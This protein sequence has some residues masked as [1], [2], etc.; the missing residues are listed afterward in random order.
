MMST[1]APGP[2]YCVNH[3]ERETLLRCNRCE[4]PICPEC[5]VLTPTGYRCKDC[6]RSQQKVFDTAQWFDYPLAVVVAGVLSFL[7]SLIAS[8]L[9][10]LTLF[11]APVAGVIVAEAVRWITQ[12]RRSRWLYRAATLAAVIG[13]AVLILVQVA[14]LLLGRNGISL[15][16]LLWQ[17]AYIALVGSTVFYRLT[18]IKI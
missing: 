11:V 17:G 1:N 9:G 14:G 6:V 15:W 7:G 2:L 16:P 3:P 13:G 8:L 4:R 5:A 10:F 12:R 18:G